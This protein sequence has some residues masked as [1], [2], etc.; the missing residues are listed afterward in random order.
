MLNNLNYVLKAIT[1]AVILFVLSRCIPN[2]DSMTDMYGKQNV[3]KFVQDNYLDISSYSQYLA[4]GSFLIKGK[5]DNKPADIKSWQLLVAGYISDAMYTVSVADDG[6]FE[7]EIPITGIQDISIPIGNTSVTFFSYP[8]DT[9][10]IYFDNNK[11]KKTLRLKGKNADRE[12]ELALCQ[13]IYKKHFAEY[14]EIINL[15]N[16]RNIKDEKLLSKLNKYYDNKIKTIKSF[17]KENGE[18]LF[19]QKFA[20]ETYFQ[21]IL[22][23]AN[24]KDLLPKIQSSYPNEFRTWVRDSNLDSVTNF[25]L[26]YKRFVTNRSYRNFLES[27]VLNFKPKG[28]SLEKDYYFALSFFNNEDIRDWYITLSLDLALAYK[29]FDE[30]SFVYN[31]FKDI[32]TN[33]NYLNLLEDKYQ[34]TLQTQSGNPAPDFELKDETGKTVR[35]SDFKGKIVYMDFWGMGCGSCVWLFQNSDAEFHEKYKDFDIVYIYINVSDN[36]V[37]WKKG[38]EKYNLQGINLIAENWTE[39]PVCKAY[40]VNGIPHY[41]LIDKEGIIVKNRCD[42]PSKILADGEKSEFDQLVRGKNL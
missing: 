24:R 38:I 19:L 13:Q 7:K 17:E 5:I 20:D 25:P 9:I 32:C 27:F 34:V 8:G 16:N 26:N 23:I 14:L 11:P 39:N 22:P 10:E 31:E 21:A 41:V 36:D 40:N 35:L 42:L 30:F 28:A 6:Y 37:N 15:A 33:K 12:K 2:A 29:D 4:D 18:F 3:E 1:F